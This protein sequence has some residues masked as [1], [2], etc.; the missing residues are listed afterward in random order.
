MSRS[1]LLVRS[2]ALAVAGVLIAAPVAYAQSTGG[3]GGKPSR[4][5]PSRP[6]AASAG[7]GGSVILFGSEE[8][9]PRDVCYG[10]RCVE[11]KPDPVVVSAPVPPPKPPPVPPKQTASAPRNVAA[12]PPAGEGRM[13][14]NVVVF[15]VPAGVSAGAIAG[16]ARGAGVEVLESVSS[17][18]LGVT[19]VRAKV[20]AGGSITATLRRL[21]ATRGVSG[22]Q[23]NY[24]YGM[25]NTVFRLQSGTR[26]AS[27][28]NQ[29][30]ES[31]VPQYALDKLNV[32]ALP[33]AGRGVR[34]AVID[35]G[36]DDGHP[37][38]K[39]RVAARF[40]AFADSQPAPDMHGTGVAG[41]IAANGSVVGV[42]PQA[43]ILAARAFGV[44]ASGAVQGSSM[45]ILKSIDWAL[46][47][48]A[49]VINMSF[50]GPKD[51][52]V[53]RALAAAVKSG[54]IPVA[55]AGN[56]GPG[57]PPAF[58]GS[59]PNVIAV[60]ATDA[61]DAIYEYAN[62]GPYVA[63]AAPGVDVLAPA[64]GGQVQIMSGT[65]MAAA[66]VS[67]VVALM[68]AEGVPANVATVRKRLLDTARDL[69]P[70]GRDPVF[71]AGLV[72]ASAAAKR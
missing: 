38:L 37:Y 45:T 53:A 33:A 49:R 18:S 4:A 31:A 47:Q 3:D 20:A 22:A 28:G 54:A 46:S 51:P 50:A 59:D 30:T 58:P 44:D 68:L 65:S 63:V 70:S 25:P 41:L 61:T 34:V 72:D 1:R 40:D 7:G 24:L 27:T 60:T 42:A 64:P 36:V 17:A 71:G 14:P 13:E 55:A 10:G 8:N 32:G 19:V 62:R 16:L 12:L 43:T 15:E 66:E 9:R 35:S 6:G 69:G 57:A 5:A 11:R 21:G 39:G 67:G 52:M 2:T 23:P 56:A 26:T 29:P 48:Q